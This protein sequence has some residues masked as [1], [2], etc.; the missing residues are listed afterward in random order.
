V[1]RW[2]HTLY[3]SGRGGRYS[4]ELGDA[5]TGRLWAAFN[6]AFSTLVLRVAY[7]AG[8][9]SPAAGEEIF[10]ET[11]GAMVRRYLFRP[12]AR[13]GATTVRGS[14]SAAACPRRI[15]RPPNVSGKGTGRE[16]GP[17]SKPCLSLA[18]VSK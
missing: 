2:P 13:P 6:A 1:R 10:L 11:L 5:F 9:A 14:V 15:V 16:P 18:L 8:F 17:G 3:V 7:G 12:E 4:R